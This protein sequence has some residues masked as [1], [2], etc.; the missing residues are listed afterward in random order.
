MAEWVG[1]P[2]RLSFSGDTKLGRGESGGALSFA[3]YWHQ[4]LADSAIFEM[5]LSISFTESSPPE[6]L[7][8]QVAAACT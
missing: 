7:L 2:S 4:R 1:M 8:Q 6:S 5:L 3:V